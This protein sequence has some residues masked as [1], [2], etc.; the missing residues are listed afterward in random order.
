MADLVLISQCTYYNTRKARRAAAEAAA[1]HDNLDRPS[2]AEVSDHRS[3][4]HDVEDHPAEDEPLLS[5]QRSAVRR[6]SSSG[7]NRPATLP[8]SHVRTHHAPRRT[9]SSL[10]PLTRIVTGEMDEPP[11]SNPWLHNTLSVLA[12]YCVGILGW[13]I[14]YRMGVWDVPTGGTD[15]GLDGGTESQSTMTVGMMLGYFSAVCYLCARI[16][17]I[18]KNYREKSCEGELQNP[19]VARVPVGCCWL[20]LLTVR[21]SRP[22]PSLLPAVSD[23]KLNVRRKPVRVFPEEGGPHQGA[24]V[25]AGFARD[26][27]RGLYHLCAVQDLCEA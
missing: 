3:H 16:P 9:E 19:R 14:G 26:H 13:F 23:G 7:V 25:A 4:R 1:E 27:G 18:I 10:D 21:I 24:S 5:R 17:Q 6:T 15:D 11:D 8:G 22:G 2:V 12:V 20:L